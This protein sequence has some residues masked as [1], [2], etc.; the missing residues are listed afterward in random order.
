ME[1]LFPL[2][3]TIVCLH[4]WSH[5]EVFLPYLDPDHLYSLGLSNLFRYKLVIHIKEFDL[6]RDLILSFKSSFLSLK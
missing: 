6:R 3:C 4:F 2:I 1:Y 5:F